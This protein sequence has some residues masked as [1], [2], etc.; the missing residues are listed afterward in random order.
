MSDFYNS[1]NTTGV[2]IK[3]LK[4][5][6]IDPYDPVPNYL[7]L[8]LPLRI[9]KEPFSERLPFWREVLDERDADDS[10]NDFPNY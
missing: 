3:R 7:E 6:P 5:K 2:D 4:W 9:V 8:T 1:R 10:S